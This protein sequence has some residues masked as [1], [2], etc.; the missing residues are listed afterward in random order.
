MYDGD[1]AGYI[2]KADMR[3]GGNVKIPMKLP[4][5]SAKYFINFCYSWKY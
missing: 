5:I 3:I 2:V 4:T 1:Y